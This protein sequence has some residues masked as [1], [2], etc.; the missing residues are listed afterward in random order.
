MATKCHHCG[1]EIDEKTFFLSED[2]I[3]D[4]VKAAREAHAAAKEKAQRFTGVGQLL[5]GL[6][7]VA[8]LSMVVLPED[9]KLIGLG[10]GALFAGAGI[11]LWWHFSRAKV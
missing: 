5:T 3:L 10:L 1:A 11:G 8:C 4:E 2:A 6:G 9:L 7:G